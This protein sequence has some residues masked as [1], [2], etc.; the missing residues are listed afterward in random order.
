MFINKSYEEDLMNLLVVFVL[1]CDVDEFGA[2]VQMLPLP[3]LYEW[4]V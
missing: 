3:L 4:H 2:R 1:S